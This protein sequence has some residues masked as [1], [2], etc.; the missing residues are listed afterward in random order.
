MLIEMQR[1]SVNGNN[2]WALSG[3]VYGGAR[4]AERNDE[5]DFRAV[6]PLL[7]SVGRLSTCWG[8][9][10]LGGY[11]GF[12]AVVQDRR[13]TV[14]PNVFRPAPTLCTTKC[15]TLMYLL[16]RQKKKKNNQKP[17]TQGKYILLKYSYVL[18]H[19]LRVR[20]LNVRFS[21]GGEP[22]L[23]SPNVLPHALNEPLVPTELKPEARRRPRT[24][25]W[26][27]KRLGSSFLFFFCPLYTHNL[28]TQLWTSELYC[29]VQLWSKW[30]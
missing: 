5:R 3:T 4:P 22:S 27:Q 25:P 7:W 30:S 9:A 8:S 1:E 28:T 13:R 15:L 23:H 19:R 20:I 6:S 10:I 11:S 12:K 2:N 14:P 21:S 16:T 29:F 18:G 24:E 17:R 26:Q